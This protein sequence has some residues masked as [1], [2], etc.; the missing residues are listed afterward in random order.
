MKFSRHLT[1]TRIEAIVVL[2]FVAGYIWENYQL[3]G[4]YRIPGIPGP[5]VFPLALGIAMAACALWLLVFPEK[6]V[7]DDSAPQ[8]AE[9]VEAQPRSGRW[10]FYLMWALMLGYVVWM[11]YLG[12]VASSSLLLLSLFRLLGERR[13]TVAVPLAI[14]F[15]LV[16]QIAFAKGLQIRLPAGILAGLL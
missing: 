13:W 10:Q 4:F 16:I 2:A 6:E 3:P 8:P 14:G 1:R 12:F 11:P 7:A 9:P 15:S 5:T